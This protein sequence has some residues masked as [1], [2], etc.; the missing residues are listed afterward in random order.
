M[1]R[2]TDIRNRALETAK[3]VELCIPAKTMKAAWLAYLRLS[4]SR[5]HSQAPLTRN[6]LSSDY[7]LLQYEFGIHPWRDN[8][9]Y[10][11]GLSSS[12]TPLS[13]TE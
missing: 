4:P 11:Q 12:L 3:K 2:S 6:V 7:Q 13:V 1:Y 9:L 5:H 8:L 10:E